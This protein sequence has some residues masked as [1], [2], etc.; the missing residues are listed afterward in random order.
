[1]KHIVKYEL[2]E[3]YIIKDGHNML[4]GD[5]V[6][7]LNRKAH[8]ESITPDLLDALVKLKEVTR[9]LGNYTQGGEKISIDFLHEVEQ[10][11]E[12]ATK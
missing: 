2:I 4:S 7:D 12:K 6:T 10:L 11:I 1:M 5:I 8:L 9:A 3:G